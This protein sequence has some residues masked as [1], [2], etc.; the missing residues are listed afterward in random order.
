MGL[1]MGMGMNHWEW[2]GI[3]LKKIFPLIS[4]A[5]HLCGH[6]SCERESR[7]IKMQ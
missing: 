7:R 6:I 1:G 2:E 4:K 5:N 3:G